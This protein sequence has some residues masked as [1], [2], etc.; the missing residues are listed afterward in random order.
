MIRIE[1]FT[2]SEYDAWV[3]DTTYF[4]QSEERNLLLS[5]IKLAGFV[6]TTPNMYKFGNIIMCISSSSKQSSNILDVIEFV[7][8]VQ[9]GNPTPV[10]LP[11]GTFDFREELVR[12]KKI[13]DATHQSEQ[14][15]LRFDEPIRRNNDSTS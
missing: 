14:Y 7:I 4:I 1:V 6:M 15:E 11:T 10:D 2:N 12:L 9:E 5:V 3:L 13:M 8:S